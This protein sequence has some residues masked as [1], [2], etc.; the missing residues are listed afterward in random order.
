[1]LAAH[2]RTKQQAFWLSLGL[3]LGSSAYRWVGLHR[4]ARALDCCNAAAAGSGAVLYKLLHL[5]LLRA[6]CHL[7]PFL[8]DVCAGL[9]RWWQQRGSGG[10]RRRGSVAGQRQGGGSRRSTRPPT[11]SGLQMQG[12]IAE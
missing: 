2:R 12:S 6:S 5:V 9:C 11:P 4:P 7:T 8:L 3:A 1:V 10:K